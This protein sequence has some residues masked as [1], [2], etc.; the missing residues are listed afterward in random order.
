M[1]KSYIGWWAA[2]AWFFIGS[3]TGLLN[4]INSDYYSDLVS[5]PFVGLPFL[6]ALL[7]LFIGYRRWK[8][9]QEYQED[10]RIRNE[11]YKSHTPGAAS[12]DHATEKAETA[13]KREP[14]HTAEQ[15][16]YRSEPLSPK[17]VALIVTGIGVVMALAM[18]VCIRTAPGLKGNFAPIFQR[19]ERFDPVSAD[20]SRSGPVQEPGNDEIRNYY[21]LQRL[22]YIILDLQNEFKNAN[23]KYRYDHNGG[24]LF[25]ELSDNMYD[26]SFVEQA[27]EGDK[28]CKT[29]W[30][31]FTKRVIT[32]QKRIQKIVINADAYAD[33]NTA[34]IFNVYNPQNP[35]ELY[36][37]VAN[38]IAG[39]D[40]INDIDVM[41]AT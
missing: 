18:I 25:F 31:S 3:I 29:L 15:E 28:Q 23:I 12:D 39:Y 37:S 13:K 40:V 9:Y 38:G 21:T 4:A 7:F 32:Q 34:I 5:T 2:S 36:L 16:T 17:K 35:D 10:R 27:R 6:L 22:D 26:Q 41:D 19:Q 30:D 24:K 11:Y 20:Q 8:E 33:D 14:F 1:R